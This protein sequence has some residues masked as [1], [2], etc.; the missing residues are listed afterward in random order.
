M[1]LVPAVVAALAALAAQ[2]APGPAGADAGSAPSPGPRDA[3]P[4]G[5]PGGAAAALRP[6]MAMPSAL[7]RMKGTPALAVTIAGGVSLGS[8]E[9]GQL[10]YMT[11]LLKANPT[12][13]Q[14]RLVTGASAGS[15]NG[16]MTILAH[17]APDQRPLGPTRGPFWSTWIPLGL[18]ELWSEARQG[19]R[20]GALSRAWLERLAARLEATFR[21]GLREDCD[22]VLGVSVT[23]VVPRRVQLPS[24]GLVLPR[25]E[26]QFALRVQGRGAGRLPRL[27]NYAS[28]TDR[29]PQHLLPEGPDGEVPFEALRDLIFASSAFP[30]AFPP[31]PLRHC[32]ASSAGGEPPRCPAAAAR[33]DLFVD[34]GLLDNSPVRLAARLAG[35]GLRDDG[36]GGTRWLDAPEAGTFALAVRTTFAYVTPDA[37]AWP[38]AEALEPVDGATPALA[39]TSRI[40][41]AFVRTARAKNLVDLLEEFPAVA[42]RIVVPLRHYPAASDPLAAFMGFF[43]QDFREFDFFLGAYDARRMVVDGILPAVRRVEPDF[44]LRVPDDASADPSWRP[45]DCLRATLGERSGAAEA[46]EGPALGPFRIVLQASLLRLWDQCA[47][48]PEEARRG[49]THPHCLAAAAGRPPLLVPGVDGAA[50]VAWRRRPGERQ[51]AHA[52]RLLSALGFHWKDLDLEAA[53]GDEALPRIRERI[54]DVVAGLAGRQ[55]PEDRL[56]L[57]QVGGLAANTLAYAPPRWLVWAT[58]GRQFELGVSRRLTRWRHAAARA[59]LALQV[60]GLQSAFSSDDT[61]VAPALLLGLELRPRHLATSTWQPSLLL[62]A[63]AVLSTHDRL[64]HL[65]CPTGTRDA[66]A[67]T[68]PLLQAGLSLSALESARLQ[69]VAEW[70]PR[71]G[72]GEQALWS[73]SPALGLQVAF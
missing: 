10:H 27:T 68:R 39:L 60:H 72:A 12:L 3:A 26:E 15:T 67:C 18:D 56:L 38:D 48:L 45:L 51:A 63:G 34:G 17:C 44:R 69:V 16:F 55:P 5:A 36:Q 41:G 43:E 49:L 57:S 65:A 53:D 35:A 6:P 46:C 2:A 1:R 14:L 73:L 62:R 31:Q 20:Q 71:L 33:T 47:R 40:A 4:G 54:G 64:G 7:A 21:D 24:T 58:L 28:S 42:D 30:L 8:Y 52:A 13:G 9:A 59:H 11:E 23:R 19:G 70:Y 37:T 25:V 22:V 29:W 66:A 61:R 50:G 32:V